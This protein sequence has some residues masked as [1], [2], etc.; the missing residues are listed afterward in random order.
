MHACLHY[1][2]G[3]QKNMD[4]E[5]DVIP[6][7]TSFQQEVQSVPHSCKR[8]MA[9]V[10]VPMQQFPDSNFIGIKFNWEEFYDII[11]SSSITSFTY[12]STER[13]NKGKSKTTR[14]KVKRCT[15]IKDIKMFFV[16]L[17][18]SFSLHVR[19]LLTYIYCGKVK[20][21]YKYHPEW[22]QISHVIKLKNRSS[23]YQ[24]QLYFM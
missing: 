13:E 11:A 15:P 12:I 3:V 24:E 6:C 16:L 1:W 9:P 8:N 18:S 21:H 2:P 5:Q 22:R 20:S 7:E 23:R 17:Y 19:L 10:W 14:T 4:I